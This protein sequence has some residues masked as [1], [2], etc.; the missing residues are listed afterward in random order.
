MQNLSAAQL[1]QAADVKSQIE[2]L[3]KEL[4]DLFAGG[5]T[6]RNAAP[7]H[8]PRSTT[9]APVAATTEISEQPAKAS[10]RRR[11]RRLSPEARAR[12]SAAA[13]ARWATHRARK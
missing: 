10:R 3:Q 13:K 5:S 4:D 11:K 2:D 6:A 12:I 8:A 7:R 1:R 9:P